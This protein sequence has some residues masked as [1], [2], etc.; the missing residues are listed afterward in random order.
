MLPYKNSNMGDLIADI[1]SS[2]PPFRPTKSRKN[3]WLQDRVWGVITA[4]WS[5]KQEW[6]CEL[7]VMH[8]VFST[9]SPPNALAESPL[10]GRKNLIRLAEELLCTFLAF[11]LDPGA[12]A[13]L[14]TVQKYISDVISRDG[15]LPTTLSSA[16]AVAL[17]ESFHEVPFPC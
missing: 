8:H 1:R 11:D 12:L 14:R 5:E 9:P 13:T 16:E 2:E 17:R 10:V 6:R 15:S 3:Q 4:C 7:S